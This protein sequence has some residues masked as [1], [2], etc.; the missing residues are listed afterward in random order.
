MGGGVRRLGEE[1]RGG[2]GGV[3]EAVLTVGKG[4]RLEKIRGEG[5]KE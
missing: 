5:F 2:G 3:S 1:E 4:E